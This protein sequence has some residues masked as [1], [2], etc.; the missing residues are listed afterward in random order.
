MNQETEQ[1]KFPSFRAF[2]YRI[3]PNKSTERKMLSDVFRKLSFFEPVEN[4]RYIGFGSTTFADFVLFHKTLNT[5]EM[6]SIERRVDYRA[7]FE[8]N[9]P[10]SCIQIQYGESNDILPK[11]DWNIRTIGWLDYDEKLNDSVLQ[12]IALIST[13]SLSGSLLIVTV[14]ATGFQQPRRIRTYAATEA[15]FL[16]LFK[17]QLNR[18]VPSWVRGVN[19]QGDEM[20]KTCRK[21]ILDEIKVNLRNRNG[22]LPLEKKVE[23]KPLVNIVYSDNARMLTTGGILFQASDVDVVNKCRFEDLDFVKQELYEIKVPVITPRER[24]YLNQHLPIGPRDELKKLGLTDDEVEAYARSY[25]YSP[26]F[27]EIELS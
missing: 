25:R 16:R 4:Y 20:A 26:S 3:R 1:K 11:L 8:F 24:H 10:F 2:D 22:L 23:F 7:R 15:L 19:L 18:E 5:K 27:A 14:N 17:T 6:I 9:K 21:I 12:D 13:K